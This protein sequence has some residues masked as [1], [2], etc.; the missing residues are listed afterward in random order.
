M[1]KI[2]LLP[3][4]RIRK[5]RTPLP[6]FLAM[7]AAT[8]ICLLMIFWNV[9]LFTGN[10]QKEDELKI[11]QKDL[12]E[13]LEKVKPY[14]QMLVEEKEIS[15][16]NN[17]AK[18][19]KGTRTF[20]WWE[21]IDQVWDAIHSVRDVWI[22]SLQALD[23]PP[24]SFKMVPGRDVKVEAAISMDCF[25]AGSSSERMT[26][27]RITLKNHQRIREIFNLGLNEPPELTV[28]AQ[29]ESQ[30]GFAMQFKIDLSREAKK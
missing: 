27:F 17:V 19:I 25:A 11:K 16:W 9:Y 30:E 10:K 7:I 14:D 6:R 3:P 22:T 13:L 1:I 29:P 24:G 8:V 21:A 23:G 18:Q 15:D 20:F 12:N 5:E 26:N 4:E 28:V 2:N